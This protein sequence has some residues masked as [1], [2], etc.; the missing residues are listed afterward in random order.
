[1]CGVLAAHPAGREADR[2]EQQPD[3]RPGDTDRRDEEIDKRCGNHSCRLV[4]RIMRARHAPGVQVHA[5]EEVR[6]KTAVRESH[7]LSIY[8]A[9]G[10][11]PQGPGSVAESL[12]QPEARAT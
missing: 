11:L 1:M 12:T 8:S 4:I 9:L 2:D 6:T 10:G 7:P 5:H 3:Q